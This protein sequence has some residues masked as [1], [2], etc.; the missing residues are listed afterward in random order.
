M[1][2][3]ST[4]NFVRWLAWC[5][6]LT[7][8]SG[9]QNSFVSIKSYLL[10]NLQDLHLAS[11]VPVN[12]LP[13]KSDSYNSMWYHMCSGQQF[14]CLLEIREQGRKYFLLG[15]QG[16]ILRAVPC[17]EQHCYTF[18]LMPFFPLFHAH[19]WGR[20]SFKGWKPENGTS[21]CQKIA[22]TVFLEVQFNG[23]CILQ[24]WA[25]AQ[26]WSQVRNYFHPHDNSNTLNICVQNSAR[27]RSCFIWINLESAPC[28]DICPFLP[29]L[30]AWI[31]NDIKVSL[32]VSNPP[33]Q[34]KDFQLCWCVVVLTIFSPNLQS[35]D[36]IAV[37]NIWIC[38][39]IFL[40][41]WRFVEKNSQP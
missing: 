11:I 23:G 4:F 29:T 25:P 16:R 28:N 12:T 18:F 20:R 27:I 10:L 6:S 17:G 34:V 21:K 39:T 37:A 32:P 41:I 30:L 36:S 35:Q 38:C 13:G 8:P 15:D 40:G 5:N 33:V 31:V 2:S 24:F 1:C 22:L 7:W 14:F 3:T 19:F 9:V 26:S